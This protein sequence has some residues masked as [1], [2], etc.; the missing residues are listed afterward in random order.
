MN[1]TRAAIEK[2]R[3]TAVVLIFVVFAGIN[4]FFTMP[5]AEDPGFIIRWALIT[6]DFPGASPERVEMLVTDK[7]EKA[8]REMPEIDFVYKSTLFIA[9]QRPAYPL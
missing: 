9:N 3:I 5:R 8:I 2:N 1:I 4:T 7:L 6:T